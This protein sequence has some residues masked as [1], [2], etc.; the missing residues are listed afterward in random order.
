MSMLERAALAGT[1]GRERTGPERDG[2]AGRPDVYDRVRRWIVE[3]PLPIGCRLRPG[4]IAA[5]LGVSTTPVREALIRLSVEGLVV[6]RRGS[7]FFMPL[8][9]LEDAASLLD[10]QWLI[11]DGCLSAA[12]AGRAKTRRIADPDDTVLPPPAASSLESPVP[13]SVAQAWTTLHTAVVEALGNRLLAE[14]T[15]TVDDRLYQL[16][17]LDL[18]DPEEARAQAELLAEAGGAAASR[19]AAAL[20]SVLRCHAD[21][22]ADRLPRLVERRILEGLRDTNGAAMQGLCTMARGRDELP[23]T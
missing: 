14:V 6:N 7:G 11:L 23:M 13:D 19:D 5:A 22:F 20:R 1:V 21:G 15:R 8:P 9:S 3:A 2:R 4:D 12:S 17:L 10:A 16:R 18:A